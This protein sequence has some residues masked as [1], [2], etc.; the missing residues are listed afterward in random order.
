MTLL[1]RLEAAGLRAE[2][3]FASLFAAPRARGAVPALGLFRFPFEGFATILFI[4]ARIVLRVA[5]ALDAGLPLLARLRTLD[6]DGS[7][8]LRFDAAFALEAAPDFFIFDLV[9]LF[10]LLRAAIV[11]L[12]TRDRSRTRSAFK[13]EHTALQTASGHFYQQNRNGLSE[14]ASDFRPTINLSFSTKPSKNQRRR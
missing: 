2:V 5:R 1:G 4:F 7:F 3:A 9:V 8:E 10:D 12:S 6:E 13:R 11:K 14:D